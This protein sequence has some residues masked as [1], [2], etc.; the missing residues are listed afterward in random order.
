MSYAFLHSYIVLLALWVSELQNFTFIEIRKHDHKIDD[1]DNKF[2]L[3]RNL[4]RYVYSAS[5]RN[6]IPQK[7]YYVNV[8]GE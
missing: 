7:H 2:A 4:T 1:M 5:N 6:F 8:S 3:Y